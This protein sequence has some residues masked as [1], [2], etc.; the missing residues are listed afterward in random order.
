MGLFQQVT[1]E[2]KSHPITLFLVLAGWVAIA[3]GA[4]SYATAAEV[5]VVEKKVDRVLEL[6]LSATLRGLQLQWCVANGNKAI[7]AS[8]IDTY[9]R[10]Y[11]LLTGTRYP[12]PKCE[13]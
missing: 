1:K 11:R 7:I 8:T 5:K 3:V 13:G 6:Q 4:A 9:Q 2:M 12:L 10:E